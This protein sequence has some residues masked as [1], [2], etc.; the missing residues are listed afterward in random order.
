MTSYLVWSNEHGAWW[1]P[2]GHGYRGRDFWYA[3]RFT[4]DEAVVNCGLRTWSGKQPPEIMIPAPENT[5]D[6][7]TLDDIRDMPRR[8]SALVFEASRAA[9]DLRDL[10]RAR[11]PRCSAGTGECV[12]DFHC[13]DRGCCSRAVPG[14]AVFDRLTAEAGDR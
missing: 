14:R 6:T 5:Q 10:E 8:I 12:C 2:G 3:G 4:R 11:C 13:G 9:V 7:F 1:G